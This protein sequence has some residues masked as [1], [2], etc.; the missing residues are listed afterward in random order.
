MKE[1][2]S[3][4]SQTYSCVGLENANKVLPVSVNLP[5]LKNT[6]HEKIAVYILNPPQRSI[7]I[8][9]ALNTNSSVIGACS[10]TISTCDAV[11]GNLISINP[12]KKSRQTK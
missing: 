3:V 1:T 8:I 4:A 6:G 5:K 7:G 11:E 12:S 10:Y 2:N 9:H